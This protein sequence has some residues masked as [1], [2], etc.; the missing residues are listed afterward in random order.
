MALSRPL[1]QRPTYIGL[2]SSSEFIAVALAPLIG[3]ALTTKLNWRWCFYILP[4]AAAPAD[5]ALSL[6][7]LPKQPAQPRGTVRAQI[8]DLDIVGVIFLAPGIFCFLL[9]LQ[10]G[11][12]SY[13]WGTARIIALLII[14][15]V[16][17]SGFVLVE[18]K[19]D[20]Q[21][22]LPPRVI[23]RGT[24]LVGS[25][26]SLCLTSSLAIAQYYVSRETTKCY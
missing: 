20:E 5:I 2:I 10:W 12:S 24:I 21:A 8:Q 18:R 25:I 19:K 7:T 15:V 1:H 4:M 17:L 14:S 23:R 6:M 22:M 9:A 11:G 3:G 13:G 26:Y 16:L